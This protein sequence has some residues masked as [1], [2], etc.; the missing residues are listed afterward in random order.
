MSNDKPLSQFQEESF[1]AGWEQAYYFDSL[2]AGSHRCQCFR[3]KEKERALYREA[4]RIHKDRA[5][6]EAVRARVRSQIYSQS[7]YYST[8]ALALENSIPLIQDQEQKQKAIEALQEYRE[9]IAALDAESGRN[10]PRI[11]EVR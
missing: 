10:E 3:C 1:R 9:R 2:Q 6:A 11:S 8:K 5:Q 7:D 4:L